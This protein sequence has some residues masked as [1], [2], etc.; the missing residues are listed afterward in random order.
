MNG[1]TVFT[2]TVKAE[3]GDNRPAIIRLRAALK[4][5]LRACRLRCVRLAEGPAD[6][7]D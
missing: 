1:P 4:Y 6:E 2:I 3:P 5:L 7:N